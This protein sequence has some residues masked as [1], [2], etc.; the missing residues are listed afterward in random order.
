MQNRAAGRRTQTGEERRGSQTTD[1]ERDREEGE[2]ERKRTR[3]RVRGGRRVEEKKKRGRLMGRKK[4]G[5]K[6]ECSQFLIWTADKVRRIRSCV[7]LSHVWQTTGDCP[8]QMRSHLEIFCLV[9]RMVTR[10]RT[11]QDDTGEQESLIAVP[12]WWLPANR[13]KHVS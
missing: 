4:E 10:H 6:R 2:G 5:K 12:G 11:T 1:R 7:S 13:T 9:Y 3:G 8:C